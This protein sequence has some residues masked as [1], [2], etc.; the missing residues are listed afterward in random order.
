MPFER[1][2][3]APFERR[4]RIARD[5]TR[6]RDE[7][8][9]SEMQR[10]PDQTRS[11]PRCYLSDGRAAG[12]VSVQRAALFVVGSEQVLVGLNERRI[13]VGRLDR[14]DDLRCREAGEPSR[15]VQ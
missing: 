4:E 8:T 13:V 3:I 14:S 2:A 11:G 12:T 10:G 15:R 5:P 7:D 9:K 6:I 1:A